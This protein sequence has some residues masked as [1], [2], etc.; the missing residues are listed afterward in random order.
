MAHNPSTSLFLRTLMA[1]YLIYGGW[2]HCN[3]ARLND[4]FTGFIPFEDGTTFKKL[5]LKDM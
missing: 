2:G 1:N 4:D 3:I 5:R